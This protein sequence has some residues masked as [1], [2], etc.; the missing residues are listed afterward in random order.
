MIL[1]VEAVAASQSQSPSFLAVVP[2]C[3]TARTKPI[4][5]RSVFRCAIGK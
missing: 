3:E 5:L 1:F 2:L 4:A